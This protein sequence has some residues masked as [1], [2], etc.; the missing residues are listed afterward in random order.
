MS[1][2]DPYSKIPRDKKSPTKLAITKI[3]STFEIN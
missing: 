2:T 1:S 3:P